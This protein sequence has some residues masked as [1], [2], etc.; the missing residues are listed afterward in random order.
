MIKI[1][2]TYE[3]E[4]LAEEHCKKVKPKLENLIQEKINSTTCINEKKVLSYLKNNLEYI[5]KEDSCNLKFVINSIELNTSKM[6]SK[7]NINKIIKDIFIIN[8]YNKFIESSSKNTYNAYSFVK[9][10]N[11]KVCPYCNRNYITVIEKDTR[12][13]KENQKRRPDIEHFYPKSLYPYLAMSFYNLLPA[14]D[15]CNK[16]KSSF[17]SYT[18]G[19]KSPYEI[20]NDDFIFNYRV[21]NA[22]FINIEINACKNKT[23]TNL[24]DN[25]IEISFDDKIQANI[26]MLGLDKAYEVHKDEVKKIISKTICY[27]EVYGEKLAKNFK[28]LNFTG[29]DIFEY[30]FQDYLK[31]DHFQNDSLSKL[32]SDIFKN[33]RKNLKNYGKKI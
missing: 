4:K 17:D 21:N 13:N 32:K 33:V 16:L 10:L 25:S 18:E 20:K 14:C 19:A 24:N 31:E 6:N 26:D 3:I 15:I 1:E 9:N 22:D 7:E 27:N 23:Q 8:G 2:V 30:V 29:S 5:L 12:V 11:I 28:G